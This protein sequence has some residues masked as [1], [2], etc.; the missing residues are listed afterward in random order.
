MSTASRVRGL[1]VGSNLPLTPT[2]SLREREH[3]YLSLS[4]LPVGGA[5]W[6]VPRPPLR[7]TVSASHISVISCCRRVFGNGYRAVGEHWPIW[8]PGRKCV[9]QPIGVIG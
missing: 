7:V 6:V 9:D 5:G 8:G 3:F 4:P 2:L 1:L